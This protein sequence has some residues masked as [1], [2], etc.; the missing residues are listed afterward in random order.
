MART[1]MEPQAR[2][3]LLV[4]AATGL[5]AERGVEHTAVSDIV[6]Q[7]GVAQGT[8]YLYF[9]SKS[10]VVNAVV[11][12]M[13]E[14][15]V[16]DTIAEARTADAPALQKL[17]SMRDEMLSAVSSDAALLE[18]FHR[19]GNEAIHDRISRDV[20]RR[21]VPAFEDVIA[22]GCEEGVFRTSHPDDA[23]RFIAALTD[24]TDPFDVF[25]EPGRISHH[26][27]A[28]TEFM[29][30]GLGCEDET[31]AREIAR[32]RGEGR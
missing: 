10:D 28:I 13:S 27:E 20:V 11:E 24:V 15:V 16:A 8:F 25:A 32:V 7:A 14:R 26:I 21:V 18:F 17:L 1:R 5:F 30:R 31:I 3:A 6:S 4:T 29:L 9:E 2:R 23:A 19:P 22:Q 12:Q